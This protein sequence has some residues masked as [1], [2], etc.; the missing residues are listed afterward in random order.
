MNTTDLTKVSSQALLDALERRLL[1]FERD[2]QR[3]G[4]IGAARELVTQAYE[5]GRS[6][7]RAELLQQLALR[8]THLLDE[9]TAN[10]PDPVEAGAAVEAREIYW[11]EGRRALWVLVESERKV[12]EAE[13]R[14]EDQDAHKR[15][16][17]L[18]QRAAEVLVPPVPLRQRVGQWLLA[19]SARMAQRVA[20]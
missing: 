10:T 14:T 6:A 17:S 7:G 1:R 8:M 13:A 16:R 9:A 3:T 5:A 18:E 12:L 11:R 19:Q 4:A 2:A 20:S 15:R